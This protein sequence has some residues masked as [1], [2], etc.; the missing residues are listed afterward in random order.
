MGGPGALRG[1]L[2]FG[3]WALGVAGLGFFGWRGGLVSQLFHVPVYVIFGKLFVVGTVQSACM[4][5][6]AGNMDYFLE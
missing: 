1:P 5:Y 2:G 3:P 4:L 6:D